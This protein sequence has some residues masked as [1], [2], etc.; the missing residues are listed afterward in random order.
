MRLY[1]LL[2]FISA[3]FSINFSFAQGT[4]IGVWSDLLPYNRAKHVA[5]G[6]DKV[7]CANDFSLFIYDREDNSVER[8]SKS[9]GLSEIGISSMAYNKNAQALMIAF[10][11]SV[12]I[13][14]KNDRIINMSDIRRSS[15][16]GGKRINKIRM[17]NN[18]AYLA[19]E[20]G[21]VVINVS[22]ELVVATYIFGPNGSPIDVNDVVVSNDRIFAL[23]DEGI[24][25]AALTAPNLSDFS[26]WAKLSNTPNDQGIYSFGVFFND[27]SYFNLVRED[28][29]DEILFTFDGTVWDEFDREDNF[30]MSDMTTSENHLVISYFFFSHVYNSNLDRVINVFEYS[31]GV[32]SWPNAADYDE[33]NNE[34]FMADNFEG[35]VKNFNF[36]STE[37]ISVNSPQTQSGFQVA[38]SKDSRWIVAGGVNSFY[39]N[40]FNSEGFTVSYDRNDWKHF[41]P[42]SQ[43]LLEEDVRDFVHV[44]IDPNNTKKAYVCSYGWGV[45]EVEDGEITNLYNESNSSLQAASDNDVFVTSS[46]FDNDGNL[47]VSNARTTQLLS[48]KKAADNNWRGYSFQGLDPSTIAGK[49]IVHSQSNYKWMLLPRGGGVLVFDDNGTLDNTNDDRFKVLRTGDGNGNLTNNDVYSIAED[50]RGRIWVGTSEGVSVFFNPGGVFDNNTDASRIRVVQDGLVEDLLEKETITAI[51]I[52]GADRKW[53]GTALGGVFLMSADGTE[54]VLSFNTDNSPLFSNT[55]IDIA[56]DPSTGEVVFTTENGIAVYKGDATEPSD[57]FQDVYAY[58]NPVRANFSGLIGIKGLMESSSVKITDI[59]GTLVYETTSNGGQATWDG[60]NQRGQKVGTGVYLVFATDSEG[61]EKVVT[62]IL[63]IN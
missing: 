19:C 40:N 6:G 9:N 42:G 31:G 54:E 1:R 44:N 3:F 24:W 26:N 7:Y 57:F 34:L 33:E 63:F 32:A 53:F 61:Q 2:V 22:T 17:L 14:L 49:V 10:E 43:N 48:V 35:L 11:N 13:I 51:A 36:T 12:I 47:W 15:I 60:Y 23:T 38:L 39:A 56:I 21:I 30:K 59:S 37:I 46:T 55:I 58:P 16:L 45:F 41:T 25:N 29:D 4:G 5:I 62:K 27:K 18:L 20:F 8:L 28:F 52:D 50:K